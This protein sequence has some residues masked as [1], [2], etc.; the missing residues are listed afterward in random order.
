M[1]R[2]RSRK[3]GIRNQFL[4][5]WARNPIFASYY[6]GKSTYRKFFKSECGR[7]GPN[8]MKTCTSTS[9]GEKLAKRTQTDRLAN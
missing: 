9:I 1:R 8:M 2:E 3:R 7:Y 5:G 4:K 6:L